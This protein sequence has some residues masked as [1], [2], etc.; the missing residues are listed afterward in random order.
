MKLNSDDVNIHSV[1]TDQSVILQSHI[2]DFPKNSVSIPYIFVFHH[3]LSRNHALH[4][5]LAVNTVSIRLQCTITFIYK[6]S[7]NNQSLFNNSR[8]MS[9][10]S[11]SL[12][13]IFSRAYGFN[14]FRLL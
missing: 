2:H 10:N 11:L 5:I 7:F 14:V 1:L 9:V 12:G 8:I 3:I 13:P 6:I 4:H